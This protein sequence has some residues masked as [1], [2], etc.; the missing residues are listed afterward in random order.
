MANV[1]SFASQTYVPKQISTRIRVLLLLS[2]LSFIHTALNAQQATPPADL[3]LYGVWGTSS[4]DVWV[5]GA[6]R[7]ADQTIG[8]YHFNGTSWS[9][10]PISLE[11]RDQL[12]PDQPSNQLVF[13]TISG[14]ATDN[15]YAVVTRFD[16]D[17]QF[18][19][20]WD[21]IEW[22]IHGF[23]SSEKFFT[24]YVSPL[25]GSV[26]IGGRG[27]A[28]GSSLM[29]QA[30]G[31][32]VSDQ[33]PTP[34]PKEP[35]APNFA[36]IVSGI[37]FGFHV[38]A[39]DSVSTENG[40][41]DIFFATSNGLYKFGGE[42]PG[43]QQ[44]LIEGF[45][46]FKVQSNELMTVDN[47]GNQPDVFITNNTGIGA[48]KWDG[49]ALIGNGDTGSGGLDGTATPIF[50]GDPTTASHLS[51][52]RTA[53]GDG[54]PGDVENI[55]AASNVLT[56]TNNR[57][58]TEGRVLKY[59]FTAKTWDELAFVKNRLNDIILFP[60]GTYF[61]VGENGT[62]LTN[63]ASGSLPVPESVREILGFTVQVG[64]D[65]LLYPTVSFIREASGPN[66]IFEQSDDLKNWTP[67]PTDKVMEL[68]IEPSN[69]GET[70]TVQARLEVD[71]ADSPTYFSRLL[72][73]SAVD[74]VELSHT[75]L[76]N[77]DDLQQSQVSLQDFSND[78]S[79]N[80]TTANVVVDYSGQTSVEDPV[81]LVVENIEGSGVS[82]ANADG[83]TG[84]GEPFFDLTGQVRG[85]SLDPGESTDFRPI[86]FNNTEQQNFDFVVRLERGDPRPTEPAVALEIESDEFGRAL[87]GLS[88]QV[89][90]LTVRGSGTTAQTFDLEI[91][92]NP[93]S[94][95]SLSFS[96]SNLLTNLSVTT[97]GGSENIATIDL[98]PI[99]LSA[100]PG[101]VKIAI[102]NSGS[103][104][105]I[106]ELP[107]TI[108]HVDILTGAENNITAQND[109]P[110]T[111]EVRVTPAMAGVQIAFEGERLHRD[112]ALLPPGIEEPGCRTTFLGPQATP[113]FGE[114]LVTDANGSLFVNITAGG[115]QGTVLG[116]VTAPLSRAEDNFLFSTTES[117]NTC[118]GEGETAAILD[119]SGETKLSTTD[120]AIP[121]RGLNFAL[122]RTYR[123]QASHLRNPNGDVGVDWCFSY[124]DDRIMMDG[125]NIQLIRSSFRMDTFTP[126]AVHGVYISPME[127]Y[128]RLTEN[129]S[130]GYDL[131]K[132]NGTVYTYA[133]FDSQT[134]NIDTS[135]RLL[136]IE[137]RN[138][139]FKSFLYDM[140]AGLSKTV[141][142]HVVDTMGRPIEYRYY[143]EA[144]AN[145][146]RRG[147]LWQ[148]ED[149]RR[150]NSETGRIV[151][152]DYDT[153]GNMTSVTHPA[154][155]GTPNGND[156][157]NGK[158]YRY[159]YFTLDELPFNLTPTQRDRLQH[160][161][162]H[163]WSPNQVGNEPTVNPQ[164]LLAR[165]VFTYGTDPS[166][167]INFDRVQTHRLGGF[168]SNGN[169]AGGTSTYSYEQVSTRSPTPNDPYLRVTETDR[170][171]NVEVNTFS[172]WDTQLERR[173]LTRGLRNEEP[174]AYVTSYFYDDDKNRISTTAPEGDSSHY[175]YDRSN[176]DRAAQ[177][178]MIATERLP[179]PRGGDQSRIRQSSENEP[180]YQRTARS[181]DPRGLDT[182]FEAPVEDAGDRSQKERY[183]T[184]YLF[185]YQEGNPEIVLE[186][187]AETLNIAVSNIQTQLDV[188]GIALGLGDL[189]GDGKTDQ[190]AGNVV[191]IEYP[192]VSLLPDSNQVN[193]DGPLQ[194][195]VELRVYNDQ[196]QLVSS[197]D[198]EGNEHTYAY[199]PENNPDGDASPTATPPD[200]RILDSDTGGYLRQQ[201]RDVAHLVGANSGNGA[202]P[203]NIKAQ[204]FYDDVGNRIGETDARGV[205]HDYVVNEHNEVVLATRAASIPGLPDLAP[206][207]PEALTAFAYEKRA[208]YDANGNV[209][210]EE[211]EDRGNTSNTDGFI[212]TTREYDI[213]DRVISE[214]REVDVN[215]SLITQYRYDANE[216]RTL[217]VHPEGNAQTHA[218]DERDLLFEETR[219]ALSETFDTINPTF[220]FFNPRGGQAS[221][222]TYNYDFNGNLTER[223]DAEDTD[224]SV[225]NGSSIA[226]FGDATTRAYD[227]YNRQ[228]LVVDAVGNES[229]TRYDPNGNVIEQRSRGPIGGPSPI[230]KLGT[231]NVD[232]KITHY[233]HD[234]LS[235]AYQVDQ[236]LF[237]SEGVNT[238][239]TPDIA[240]SILTPGD[241]NVSNR[242]EY[243]RASRQTFVIQD[244]GDTTEYTYDGAGRK[245]QQT[246]PEGNRTEYAYDDNNNLIES[247]ETDVSQINGISDEVFLTTLYYDSLNRLS[248]RVE[249]TVDSIAQ[250]TRYHYD[251]RDNLVAVSDSNGLLSGQESQRRVF[252]SVI[253]DTNDP[254]NV[255]LYTY[256]GLNRKIKEDVVLTEIIPGTGAKGSGNPGADEF[257][258]KADVAVH[259]P[260][261]DQGGGD[262]L[263]TTTYGYDGNSLQ[264]SL[265]DDNG[266]QT[267][268]AYDNLNR[269]VSETK[270]NVVAP[271]L[272]DRND[273][274]TTIT[275]TYDLDHNVVQ[276][277]DE[278]GSIIDYSFDAINRRMACDA[279]LGTGV[280]GTTR[281]TFEYDG[282]SRPTKATDN[283]V[284]AD[285]EDDSIVTYAYDS[286]NRVV[287]ETQK[288]GSLPAKAISTGWRA[289]NLKISHVYP[290]SRIV[291]STYDQL[292]RLNTRRDRGATKDLVDYDYIGRTRVLERHF[293]I[294]GTRMTYLNDARDQVPGYDTLRRAV[295]LRHLRSDNSLIAG[296]THS[297]DLMNNKL[298]EEKLHDPDNSEVYQYDSSYRLIN[299]DRGLLNGIKTAVETPTPNSI[300]QQSWDL[301]GLGNWSQTDTT[302]GGVTVNEDR[303]H[304]SFNELIARGAT[305]LTHDD[306]GNQL[307]NGSTSYEWD[308]ANRLRRITRNSDSAVIATYTYDALGRRIRKIVSNGG[309]HNNPNLD[310]V[311][312]FYYLDWQVCE[313]RDEADQIVKQ[314]VYGNL[315]DEVLVM[316][317]N[318]DNDSSTTSAADSR[319]MYHQNN[320]F[321]TYALTDE[322]GVIV[323]LYQYDPYGKPDFFDSSGNLRDDAAISLVDNP[324]LYTGRRNEKE[325]ALYNYRHRYYDSV[326]GRFVSRDPVFY[327]DGPNLYQ[328]AKS[329]PNNY[330]DPLGLWSQG[331]TDSV[332]LWDDDLFAHDK[333]RVFRWNTSWHC[334]VSGGLRL[335]STNKQSWAVRQSGWKLGV[336]PDLEITVFT[337]GWL[338]GLDTAQSIIIQPIDKYNQ[339]VTLMAEATTDNYSASEL[340]VGVGIAVGTT[341]LLP[342]IAPVVLVLGVEAGSNYASWIMDFNEEVAFYRRYYVV[343]CCNKNGEIPERIE[344]PEV[345]NK[346][347][348]LYWKNHKKR[349]EW[350]PNW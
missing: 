115:G 253:V 25:T 278:N 284:F 213:L 316:D 110:T 292:D 228:I 219:G 173:E 117:C 347:G 333:L 184:K 214:T 338:G 132:P 306:N 223:V 263:I 72:L 293:P 281:Q 275:Y 245:I 243:D 224:F 178:N 194:E 211:I 163:V 285:P 149:F 131:R 95:G 107:I 180:I 59:D 105:V 204:Y 186:Q 9:A 103:D 3:D 125:K 340:V 311:I 45:G 291:D 267:I 166:D 18:V 12:F 126:T 17:G 120:L 101:D 118:C 230:D 80:E 55:V 222:V 202:D 303:Q 268:H 152:Y 31:A 324:Y 27:I 308:Y 106:T 247:R 91:L 8:L 128:E 83:T 319:F 192:S 221:K 246:D 36:V 277:T 309:L 193:T 29:R 269:R 99:T 349:V 41:E 70:E 240:D 112:N 76:N 320:Q 255:T 130:G 155:L 122:T 86:V 249:N 74:Q 78:R 205:R 330:R 283:N 248:S 343:T 96:P 26:Y 199:Y 346:A 335:A 146:G 197:T 30:A 42:S 337:L 108:L 4:S 165:E 158:T 169:E 97:G 233:D 127:S 34:L 296:T 5:A 218:Y 282:L 19:V 265:T 50:L 145:E 60:D 258:V 206:S 225:A 344:L 154:I 10:A 121:G 153:E 67:V 44:P 68:Q 313:E 304:S 84:S 191:R 327:F 90:P 299:F 251:S 189:N 71:I 175:T 250:T 266:N 82:V 235:R 177:G 79:T 104:Q 23:I 203:T 182:S 334:D 22:K 261:S 297:Y 65:G 321:S 119:Y 1:R 77:G 234:E 336:P 298:R 176:S 256:D 139:N 332:E 183:T 57:Q 342:E 148:V 28:G 116:T 53:N 14:N 114:A 52:Y 63:D 244:D 93:G 350:S 85:P 288:I 270:G 47:E 58:T 196:G 212:E 54:S 217:V 73:R 33:D 236:A 172:A 168:D 98:R 171:G 46:Q 157:P 81:I 13:R 254:G 286:L 345:D 252:D 113:L 264:S 209:V 329:Q 75:I 232:L 210:R 216:N 262:G 300:Q 200:S 179:G 32:V 136:R 124:I 11:L 348:D 21:G 69:D 38:L 37:T 259:S 207:E 290:N 257:G 312:H 238:V 109:R 160:N 102:K 279:F 188:A 323:E 201:S 272:A 150:D 331:W 138:G 181:I 174:D 305:P 260:D 62:I 289:E 307:S 287:E 301:D 24:S 167:E 16:D 140:P 302:T 159:D 35:A 87:L 273:P 164:P 170:R 215:E 135:G 241:S 123:S 326:Q 315:I 111:A 141:L 294:N 190:I 325:S 229:R 195:I 274:N 242:Y 322:T 89:F 227:G 280:I 295:E 137:D 20:R 129:D 161:L 66:D 56:V 144:D 276:K 49:N 48:F 220:G 318:L 185:D 328:Y 142:T 134:G 341:F 156:F 310:G 100:F 314:Y 187:L 6:S 231:N 61:A 147:R 39:I 198:P 51:A 64:P 237:V 317:S 271:S 43:I 151:T 162:T 208:Y 40:L 15:I 2:I 239:R 94:P 339:A 92:T 7:K 143:D 133:G 88:D 226:G